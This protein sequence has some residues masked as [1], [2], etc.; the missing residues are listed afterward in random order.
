MNIYRYLGY[1]AYIRLPRQPSLP[2]RREF[3]LAAA[4]TATNWPSPPPSAPRSRP[5][6]RRTL[7]RPDRSGK[8]KGNA[9][10]TEQGVG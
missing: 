7:C 10:N 4:R 8:G 5:L 2:L 6:I 1:N 9:V 3:E